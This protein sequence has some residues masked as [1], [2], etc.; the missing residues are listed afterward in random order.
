MHRIYSE[1]RTKGLNLWEGDGRERKVDPWV[2]GLTM[3]NIVM[4]L[5]ELGNGNK[6][7]TGLNREWWEESTRVL[8]CI[9]KGR[10]KY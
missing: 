3:E 2:F 6:A 9:S 1:G 8:L 10:R 7:G 4:I 5:R